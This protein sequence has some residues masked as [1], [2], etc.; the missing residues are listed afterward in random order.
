MPRKPVIPVQLTAGPFTLADARRAGLDRWHL[1]GA[2]WRRSGPSTYVWAGLTE[3]PTLRL[4]AACLRLPPVAAFSG[5][6]A[7]WLHGIDVE[8]CDP[9]EA[10]IPKGSGASA[11]SGLVIRRAVLPNI[12]I[13]IV[14]GL[15]ATTINRTLRDLCTRLS[16]TEAVVVVDMALHGRIAD[17]KALETYTTAL[18]HRGGVVKL[19]RV[20]HLAEP[21]SESPMESRLRTLLVLTGLPR[22][23]AQMPL[24]DR[25]GRFLGRPDLYYSDQRLAIEYDGGIHRDRMVE[26]NRR[27]NRLVGEGIRLLRFTAGDI[28]SRPELVAAQVRAALGMPKTQ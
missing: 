2:S 4:K 25:K 9:I 18:S 7:A 26:D 19:R 11:L 27:Q 28:Y 12:D 14:H 17:L 6:T 13:A 23:Q 24:V 20:I 1:E 3:S 21:L 16:L 5:R 10:T 8:P 22:P 15:R